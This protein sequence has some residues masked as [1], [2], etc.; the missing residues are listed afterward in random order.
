MMIYYY[1][2]YV[3]SYVINKSREIWL[4]WDV[5]VMNRK[6]YLVMNKNREIWLLWLYYD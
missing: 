5:C 4:L 2:I 1:F 6:I 3:I